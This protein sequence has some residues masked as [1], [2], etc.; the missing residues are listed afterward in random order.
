MEAHRTITPGL[1]RSS[2]HPHSSIQRPTTVDPE[3]L[4]GVIPSYTT[5]L[6]QHTDKRQLKKRMGKS[7][8]KGGVIL[9]SIYG[10]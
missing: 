2:T 6:G 10:Y 3:H 5:A 7:D 4:L 9:T 8:L 1:K